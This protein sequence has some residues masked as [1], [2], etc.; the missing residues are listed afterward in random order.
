[1]NKMMARKGIWKKIFGLLP[2]RQK[3][4]FFLILAILGVSAILSQLTP[5][6]IGY[7]T[8]HILTEQS[9]TF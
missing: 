3:F 4:G 7:L 6:A 8:D 1:M 2:Q 9:V 5:L